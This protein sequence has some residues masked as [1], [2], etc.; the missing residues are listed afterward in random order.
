MPLRVTFD[1]NVLDLACRPDRF[2]KDHRQPQM[3]K[4]KD[5]LV[6]GTIQGFYS[7]TML[8]IE[9]IMRKDRA[10]VFAG[11]H[12]TQGA[13]A[14]SVTRNV[15]LPDTIRDWVGNGDVTTIKMEYRV[16][17]PGRKQLHSEVIAR[18][19]AAQA[20]GVRVLHDVPRIGA[21]KINDSGQEFYLDN[22]QGASLQTWINKA[23]EVSLAIEAKGVGVA[24]VK[25][26]GQSIADPAQAWFNALDNAKDIHEERRVERAFSEWADGDAIAAHVAYGLDVFCS[27]DVGNSNVTNSV[28]DPDNRAWLTS[29]YGVK[30][31]TF[32]ELLANC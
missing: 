16:E 13:E 4:I 14:V 27:A 5:A 10:E 15:D 28:L 23:H 31:M 3:H 18:V 6:A 17:Q 12:I 25:S 8:T 24:Q 29:N 20:L 9:G 11:T 21:F 7:L 26:L 22:G 2:P 1:T 32:D 30:F 19:K